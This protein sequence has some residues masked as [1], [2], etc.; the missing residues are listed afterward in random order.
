MFGGN[1]TSAKEDQV[2]CRAA[3]LCG[4]EFDRLCAAR[5]APVDLPVFE[6][7]ELKFEPLDLFDFTASLIT[8]I[9]LSILPGNRAQRGWSSSLARCIWPVPAI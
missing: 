7:F 9:R 3:G 4:D 5:F 8:R 1:A 2:G 6:P